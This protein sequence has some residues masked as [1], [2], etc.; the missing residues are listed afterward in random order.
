[1]VTSLTSP[2]SGYMSTEG[3]IQI[4]AKVV[5][6]GGGPE[7]TVLARSHNLVYCSWKEGE[8]VRQGAFRFDSVERASKSALRLLRG[9]P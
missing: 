9:P 3:D 8:E 2:Q 5:L 1:M 7:M 6:R 4:G